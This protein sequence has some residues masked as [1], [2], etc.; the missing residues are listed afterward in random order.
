[1]KKEYLKIIKINNYK[2][3][4]C[5]KDDD[6]YKAVEN[7]IKYIPNCDL[8]HLW[9]VIRDTIAAVS[10]ESYWFAY[11]GSEILINKILNYKEKQFEI[12][13]KIISE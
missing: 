7:T 8:E 3:D 4:Y 6:I 1:M 12:I 10:F 13:G 11:N 2:R 5:M 9:K